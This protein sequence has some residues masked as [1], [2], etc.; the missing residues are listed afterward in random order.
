LAPAMAPPA[1][2]WWL[3]AAWEGYA[4]PAPAAPAAPAPAAPAQGADARRYFTGDA[5]GAG[6]G[7][8]AVRALPRGLTGA[9]PRPRPAGPGRGSASARAALSSS[10]DGRACAAAPPPGPS[11]AQLQSRACGR[12]AWA[13]SLRQACSRPAM[14][15]QQALTGEQLPATGVPGVLLGPSAFFGPRLS[16]GGWRTAPHKMGGRCMCGHDRL[17]SRRVGSCAPARRLLHTL[18]GGGGGGGAGLGGGCVRVRGGGP[19]RRGPLA[20]V[21]AGA[22]ALRR[23]RGCHR[24]A[25]RARPRL[26][27]GGW[28]GPS[29]RAGEAVGGNARLRTPV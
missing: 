22:C 23:R 16:C 26:Y 13:G 21:R 1:L 20:G 25:R 27:P 8:A 4:L 12:H 10:P 28:A 11:S 5:P 9:G 19:A 6:A 24:P 14:H 17:V 15:S 29:A 7:A 3:M 2:P 18:A